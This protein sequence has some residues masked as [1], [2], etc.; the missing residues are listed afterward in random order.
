M[1]LSI[2][3]NQVAT[4]IDNAR[5]RRDASEQSSRLNAANEALLRLN[6]TLEA[7]VASRT[8]EV[9]VALDEVRREKALTD[10]GCCAAWPRPSSFR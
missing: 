8:A 4:G 7:R 10:T 1:L 6:E 9:S 5:L 3:G 2:V